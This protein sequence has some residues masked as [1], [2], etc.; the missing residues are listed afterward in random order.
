VEGIDIIN[1]KDD[2]TRWMRGA[3]AVLETIGMKMVG[4]AG[5]TQTTVVKVNEKMAEVPD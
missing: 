1:I 3:L 4:G 5:R 2:F